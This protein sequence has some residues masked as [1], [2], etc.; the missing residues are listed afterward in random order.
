MRTVEFSFASR[1]V[2]SVAPLRP[3]SLGQTQNAIACR[4]KLA[5]ANTTTVPMTMNMTY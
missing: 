2:G 4:Q 3:H 5:M 1:S